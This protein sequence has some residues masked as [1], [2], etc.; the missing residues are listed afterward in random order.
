MNTLGKTIARTSSQ[1]WKSGDHFPRLGKMV[2]VEV[3]DE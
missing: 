2:E 3:G 1:W